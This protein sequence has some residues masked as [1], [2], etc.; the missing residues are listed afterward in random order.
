MVGVL[1]LLAVQNAFDDVPPRLHDCNVL[2]VRDGSGD[3]LRLQPVH[4]VQSSQPAVESQRAQSNSPVWAA[5]VFVQRDGV[6]SLTL[7]TV[8]PQ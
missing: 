7:S 5:V 3:H 1:D 4:Y 6:F 8:L 2:V